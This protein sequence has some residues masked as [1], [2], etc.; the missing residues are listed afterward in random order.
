MGVAVFSRAFPKGGERNSF[1]PMNRCVSLKPGMV[2]VLKRE[3][4]LDA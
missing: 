3:G 4:F 2:I 1:T